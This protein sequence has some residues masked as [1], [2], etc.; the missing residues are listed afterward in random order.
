MTNPFFANAAIISASSLLTQNSIRQLAKQAEHVDPIPLT[1]AQE[2]VVIGT[3]GV[4][5]AMLFLTFVLIIRAT[6]D[7]FR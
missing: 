7:L 6:L 5:V 2:Y 3:F 4:L 1:K